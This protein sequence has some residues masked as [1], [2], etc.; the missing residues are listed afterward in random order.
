MDG[1]HQAWW[2]ERVLVERLSGGD[3]TALVDLY[4][5]YAGFVYGLAVRTLVDPQAAEDITQEV[6]VSL[7]E[8]P[9]RIDSGRGTLRGFLGTLTHRRAVDA[10]RREE[11]HRRREARVARDAGDVPDV[12]EAVLRSD[13]SGKVRT[14]ARGAAR[15]PAAGPGPGLLPRVHVPS[16]RRRVEHS[17]GHGQV[18]AAPGVGAHRRGPRFRDRACRAND[19]HERRISDGSGLTGRSGRLRDR[20]TRRRERRRD[21]RP[22]RRQSRRRPSG[23]GPAP[24]GRRVR[25][26]RRARGHARCRAAL[27]GA[28]RG[29]APPGA[30]RGGRRLLADRRPPRRVGASHPAA[31]RPDGRRLGPTGRPARVRRLDRPR[32]RGPPGGQRVAARLPAGCAR[33]AASPRPPRTTRVA[34]PRPAPGTRGG[35]RRTPSPNWRLRRRRP[36][37]RS[38]SAARPASTSRSTGGAGVPRPGSRCWCGPSRRGPTRTTSAVPS[39]QAW[40]THRRRRFSR[41]LTPRA[42]SCRVCSPPGVPS[43]RAGSSVSDSPT[44]AAPLGTSTWEPSAGSVRPATIAVDAEI[45]TE[46]A[47]ACRTISARV[48]PRELTYEVVGDEQLARDVVDALPA[49]AVL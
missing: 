22:P 45:V 24:G 3:E 47:A 2:A 6:F 28:R 43:I 27:P 32:R 17:R 15:S 41:W 13:T 46:A 10:V 48:D 7:W 31:A 20:R 8:H 30:G 1:P 23:A 5:R 21:R 34:P 25:R 38:R 16:G 33:A 37:R 26:C 40:W 36:T 35:R 9:E 49:L 44:L 11:A 19:G 12:A 39:E 42:A 29:T 18:A 14:A 4:D